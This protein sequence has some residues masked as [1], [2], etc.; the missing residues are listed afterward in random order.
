LKASLTVALSKQALITKDI[1]LWH[2][3]QE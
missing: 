3:Q 1:L 2:T